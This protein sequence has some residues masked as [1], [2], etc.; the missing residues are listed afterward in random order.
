MEKLVIF[1][2]S[3]SK[4]LLRARRM[5]L[6]VQRFNRDNLA[7][8]LSVPSTDLDEFKR[9][10][11]SIPC[12]FLT[13]EQV[14]GRCYEVHGRPPE[15][16]PSHLIQ[17]LVKMEFW[18]MELCRHYLWIDSDAYFLKPFTCRDFFAADD[19]PLL[20]MHKADELRA[21]AR[22]HNENIEKDLNRVIHRIQTLFGRQGEA[23]YFGDPP[24]V[25][26]CDVLASIYRDF[27]K[28]R[29][30]TVFELLYNYPCEMQLY[31]EYCL[32]S[33]A[34]PFTKTEPLFK[35]FHYLEQFCDAQRKGESE[36]S[37]SERYLGVVMQSNWTNE[38]EK[39]KNDLKRFKKFLREQKRKLGMIRW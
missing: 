16:F 15:L 7:L 25:W 6:S 27:L 21:F 34:F 26:S 2:K 39:K 1:C 14:L 5:A 37:F 13:D 33:G 18:R 29:G 23:F 30:M 17:Q 9:Q 24:L 11:G 3:Y 12:N 20:V 10:F 22:T 36:Q 8:Y 38:K 35:V 4:D 28:P 31:G 19:T 32:A